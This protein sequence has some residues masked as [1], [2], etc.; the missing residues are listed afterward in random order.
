M[1]GTKKAVKVDKGLAKRV[2]ALEAAVGPLVVKADVLD[3]RVASIDRESERRLRGLEKAV[4]RDSSPSHEDPLGFLPGGRIEELEKAVAVLQSER[5]SAFTELVA[6]VA[7]TERDAE[8]ARNTRAAMMTAFEN[9]GGVVREVEGRLETLQKFNEATQDVLDGL[10]A[11]RPGEDTGRR[12]A[13][14]LAAGERAG[15]ERSLIDD[16]NALREI[17]KKKALADPRDGCD[18]YECAGVLV[19]GYNL[20]VWRSQ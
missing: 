9:M 11:P 3:G 18:C 2:A 19:I 5:D 8:N 10:T 14:A 4:G 20:I 15:R 17:T 13:E 6:R 7:K 1:S 16:V 12:V